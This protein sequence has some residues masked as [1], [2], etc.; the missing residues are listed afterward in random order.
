MAIQ[1][2]M[3]ID[4]G[5]KRVGVALSDAEAHIAF[6]YS[7]IK[8]SPTLAEDISKIAHDD[9]VEKI[10]MGESKDF[11]MIDNPL[12]EKINILKEELC[13]LGFEVVL[14]N[15]FLTSHQVSSETFGA[16]RKEKNRKPEKKDEMLDAKS[17]TILLQS[18]LDKKS[19]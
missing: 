10:I 16:N 7:V 6:P 4:F 2:I 11:N 14:H 12:M 5:T 19:I 18:Y 3:G 8:N 15:E 1:K 9:K 17:A 13:G